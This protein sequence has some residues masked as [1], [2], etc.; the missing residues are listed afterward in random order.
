MRFLRLS[1]SRHSLVPLTLV[2]FIALASSSVARPNSAEGAGLLV[3][4]GGFGGVLEIKNQDV[5]VTINNQIAVTQVDQTFVNT[6]DRIVEAL[7]TFPVPSGASVSNFSMWIEGKEMIGEVVEKARAREIYDS[8]KKVRRDPGLLEQVD[9]KQ[10]EMRIFPIAAGAEQRV[11]IEYYQELNL[12]HD[13]AT[14]IYPLATATA[15][16][17]IDTKVQGRFSINVEVLSEV[18]I[19][20][21][22]SESHADDFVV[23]NH[24]QDYAQ[25]SLEL[26]EGDLSRDVVMAF[27]TKRPRT[28]VDVV[29][30][31]PQGEDGYFMMTV[32]PGEDLSDTSEPMDYVFLLDISGSM[33]YDEKLAISRRSIVAFIESLAPEDRFECLA[34]NLAP[35]PLF[36]ESR[37]ATPENLNEAAE[38]FA[39]QRA[40]GGTVLGPALR[41]AYGYRD[42]DRPLN[43]VLLSDG[44]TEAGEQSELLNLISSRPDAVRVFCVGVGNEVNRP[45]LQQMATKAGG[46]ASFVS[47]EDSFARQA[48]LMRQKLIRPAIGNLSVSFAGDKITEVEPANL[49]N[50]FYGTPLRLLG[51][52]AD[53]GPV[54]VTLRGEIQG[55][56]WEQT[57]NIELPTKDEGHSPIERIWALRRVS[58]LLGQERETKANHQ[59]EIVRLCEGYSI[60]SPYASMLVLENDREYKRWKIEQRNAT[61]ITRD[62]ASREQLDRKLASLR[63]RN[64]Y[65]LT[66][67]PQPNKA[68]GNAGT[69]TSSVSPDQTSSNAAPQ[70]SS[71]NAPRS[72]DFDFSPNRGG[73]GGGGGAIDPITATIALT[74]AGAAALARR[75]KKLA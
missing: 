12:D 1:S 51:R 57:V 15:G 4:D 43:V 54:E 68:L 2:A 41:A 29:T 10:F 60:V 74:T 7:Y 55:S 36:Q 20:E 24:T 53:G 75:R 28:G 30:S 40:R 48:H 32:T 61:R 9:Y 16:R 38:F 25:A 62:R 59:A 72:V 52:Y 64:Q 69:D 56:P 23:V 18:P 66:S 39:S 33:A 58:R 11:R 34:F 63:E 13:W 17:P 67:A 50:L 44:M 49:G 70:S 73:G 71:P 47:T 3:A 35:T 46:L 19:K 65:Q 6:E 5:R 21:L 14:Y 8:Y 42:S 37:F 45:L 27:Q 22:T 31:R 26:G